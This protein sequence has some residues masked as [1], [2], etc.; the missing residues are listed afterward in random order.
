M[1]K[2][3]DRRLLL[4][5]GGVSL[6]LSLLGGA[7]V[8]WAKGLVQEKRDAVTQMRGEIRAAEAK[9]RQIQAKAEKYAGWLN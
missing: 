9:I 4:A 7:G 6:C 8:W 5:V 3:T 1:A 2:L